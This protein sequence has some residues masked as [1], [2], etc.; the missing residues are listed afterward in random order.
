[1]CGGFSRGEQQLAQFLH[2]VLCICLIYIPPR[3]ME[4]GNNF[5]Q[6]NL[7]ETMADLIGRSYFPPSHTNK[8]IC[9]SFSFPPYIVLPPYIVHLIWF[10]AAE[11][12]ALVPFLW[13]PSLF[14]K[15]KFDAFRVGLGS[16]WCGSERYSSLETI[17]LSPASLP[18]TITL[19]S[20]TG[21]R[22]G[23][24]PVPSW[25]P[26]N[27]C[28]WAAPSPRPYLLCV[29]LPV[30]CASWFLCT[31]A[32]AKTEVAVCP[33]ILQIDLRS[34]VFQDFVHIFLISHL[35]VALK[36][37]IAYL[38]LLPEESESFIMS[39]ENSPSSCKELT[40]V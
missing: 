12:L 32:A 22:R 18:H 21:T 39:L 1:M 31:K 10:A 7:G 23:C 13:L 4:I 25:C 40:L 5:L 8:R 36:G 28:F 17:R 14:Q 9:R 37:L 27:T 34:S 26:V 24:F 35:I 29:D 6:P 30:S 20:K 15:T 16:C 33:E 19:F 11:A 3:C 2:A 38:P